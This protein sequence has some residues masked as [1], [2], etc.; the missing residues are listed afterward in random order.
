MD[1]RKF[2]NYLF[3]RAPQFIIVISIVTTTMTIGINI[4]ITLLNIIVIILYS[5]P[6][7]R[8]VYFWQEVKRIWY[9][10]KI[11]A[12]NVLT[13]VL[14]IVRICIYINSSICSSQLLTQ[15]IYVPPNLLMP[16]CDNQIQ[17]LTIFSDGSPLLFKIHRSK[18][19]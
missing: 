17:N 1:T 4:T 7:L 13:I 6:F 5:F 19:S 10:F 11:S 14:D 18:C 2:V 12:S 9:F 16:V 3:L 8:N 15:F